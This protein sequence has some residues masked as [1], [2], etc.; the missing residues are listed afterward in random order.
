MKPVDY[1]HYVEEFNAD[2]A[3]TVATLV[4]NR[5]A[6]EWIS[7]N[8]PLFD[9][10]DK[11]LEQIYYYRWWTFR[12]HIRE[13]PY[14]LVLTEFLTPV[15]H[16]GPFNT[17]SC[18]LGHHLAEGRWLRDGRLLDDYTRFWFRS[19]ENGGP[20]THFHR[21]SSWAAAAIYD[22]YLVTGDRDFTVGLLDD[23]ISDYATWEAE[24][25]RSDGLFW[26]YD[27]RDG[28]EES[29]SGRRTAKN[30]RPTINSYMAANAQAIAAIATLAG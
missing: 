16:A 1:E 3:E 30:S 22:R 10:P 28:M 26:Q 23:L 2:D 6:W 19:G 14:G 20:A 11:K 8:A 7:E 4:P 18:A 25:G 24:R 27:V 9:C 21:F 29:I 12:K 13:T 17:I 15:G 5:R